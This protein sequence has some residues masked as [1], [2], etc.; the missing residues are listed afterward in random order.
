MD[1]KCLLITLGNP[2]QNCELHSRA[3]YPLEFEFEAS[4]IQTL[5][6]HIFKFYQALSLDH[7]NSLG[8]FTS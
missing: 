6:F 7:K 5:S 2:V 4:N 3:F 8:T 1:F